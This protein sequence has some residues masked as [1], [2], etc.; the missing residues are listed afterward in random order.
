MKA[1]LWHPW[2]DNGPLTLLSWWMPSLSTISRKKFHG[3][4]HPY[5]RQLFQRK[6]QLQ[7]WRMLYRARWHG[8][9]CTM[10]V[11]NLFLYRA[12]KTWKWKIPHAASRSGSLYCHPSPAMFRQIVILRTSAPVSWYAEIA[13]DLLLSCWLWVWPSTARKCAV[14]RRH[15]PVPLFYLHS[16]MSIYAISDVCRL[17]MAGV[18]SAASAIFLNPE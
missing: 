6:C 14:C 1:A 17:H 16:L 10:L 13:F 8:L 4:K 9:S 5:A 15:W 2:D 11:S 3:S 12:F 18:E 7:P